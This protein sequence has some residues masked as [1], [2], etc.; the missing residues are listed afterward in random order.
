MPRHSEVN[1][2]VVVSPNGASISGAV[3]DAVHA[4]AH[5]PITLKLLPAT[6]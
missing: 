5:K 2:D 6:E 1:L 3:L 4:T